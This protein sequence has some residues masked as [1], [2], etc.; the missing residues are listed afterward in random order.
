MSYT[1]QEKTH[2]LPDKGQAGNKAR[3]GLRGRDLQRKVLVEADGEDPRDCG[4]GPCGFGGSS[5]RWKQVWSQGETSYARGQGGW[6]GASHRA[7]HAGPCKGTLRPSA[8]TR[9]G[10]SG[11]HGAKKCH[12]LV[13]VCRGR[14]SLHGLSGPH[15]CPVRRARWFLLFS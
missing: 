5:S 9:A 12:D 13:H 8:F 4:S 10:V 14:S 7:S 11:G 6:S 2:L 3:G 15:L 1:R